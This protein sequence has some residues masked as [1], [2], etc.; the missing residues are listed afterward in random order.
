MTRKGTKYIYMQH[1]ES[2]FR[3]ICDV[4][5]FFYNV[6]D[7]I[8]S[9]YNLV[10]VVIRYVILSISLYSCLNVPVLE[11]ECGIHAQS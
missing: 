6:M 10:S 8:K 4:Y 5:E 3:F 9:I 2:M 7:V 1:M 11:V